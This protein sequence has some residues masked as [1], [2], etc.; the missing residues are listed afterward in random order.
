M[1]KIL[2][3]QF[4]PAAKYPPLVAISRLLADA[5]H[6]VRILGCE[7]DGAAGELKLAPHPRINENNLPRG[8]GRLARKLDYPRFLVRARTEVLRWKPDVLY[9]S[10]LR[11]YPI[12]LWAARCS[13]CKTVLHE[14]DPPVSGTGLLHRQFRAAR[15]SFARVATACVIPQDE[16]AQTFRAE[17]G[18]KRVAVVYNCPPLRELRPLGS[19]T[20]GPDFVLWYHGSIGPKRLPEAF[21]AALAKLPDDVCL[22]AAGYETLSSAGYVARLRE[23]AQSLS[24]SHRFVFHG[25][26]SRGPLLKMSEKASLGVA[27]LARDF[28]MPMVGASVK[29]FDYLACGLPLLVNDTPEWLDF[30]AAEGVAAGCNPE[31]PDDIA[32]AVLSLRDDPA[33]R[34]TMVARGHELMLTRWN[35]ELQFAKAASFLGIDLAAAAP[36]AASVLRA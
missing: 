25:P 31:S 26:V 28:G 27:A 17:T 21:I 11:S 6:E 5:G 1:T 22:E 19:A 2:Y 13:L 20:A 29:P 4:A 33:R 15:Q 30:Y 24:V 12:G 10:D 9:C 34:R 16:R 32:R 35:Y 23:L 36:A 8:T 7:E 14:H 3:V 18:A